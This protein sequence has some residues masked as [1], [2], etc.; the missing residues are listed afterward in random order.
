[1]TQSL[2]IVS[3]NEN[4]RNKGS[5]VKVFEGGE[6]NVNLVGI[7]DFEAEKKRLEKEA[8]SYKKDLEAVNKKLSNENFINKAKQEAIETEKRKQK[9][10]EDKLKGINE[11]LSSF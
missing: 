5:F 7:I 1:M 2:D 8:S 3:A 10:F 6:I 4:E 9:E 11:V